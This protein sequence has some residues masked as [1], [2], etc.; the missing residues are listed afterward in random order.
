MRRFSLIVALTALAAFILTAG[1]T[2][3]RKSGGAPPHLVAVSAANGSIHA[4]WQVP[5]GEKMEEFLYDSS[6]KPAPPASP[7][8]NNACDPES[9]CWPGNGTPLYCYYPV[10]HD[11]TGDCV[12]HF[13]LGD[14]QASFDT[15][16][17]TV[18]KTYYVQVSSMDACVAV[19]TPCDWP[20][21]YYSN[22]VPVTI[23]VTK[24]KTGGGGGTSGSGG[25]SLR[26]IEVER[27]GER[28]RA[29]LVHEDGHGHSCGRLHRADE[30]HRARRRRRRSERRIAHPHH[31]S[32]RAA[33]PRSQQPG[34]V[35]RRQPGADVASTKGRGVLPGDDRPSHPQ[36]ARRPLHRDVGVLQR[37]RGHLR[38]PRRGH[39]RRHLPRRR[40]RRDRS[41]LVMQR[42][43]NRNGTPL[44][45]GQQVTVHGTTFST[46]KRF[47]PTRYF[48]K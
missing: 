13:D 10:Y 21:E 38:R 42:G 41:G 19:S 26:R 39:D 34:R 47:V 43:S 24:S 48:W 29:R 35:R 36:P 30:E 16:P 44:Q 27:Q 1:S 25:S 9:W 23:K 22:I 37:R 33:R 45:S 46:P 15:D 7:G 14:K 12:G 28:H 31:D 32:E 5:A 40:C 4:T 3:A 20:Y 8:D 6:S 11:R 2:A 18:G 17:L